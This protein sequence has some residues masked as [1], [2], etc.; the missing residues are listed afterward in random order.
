[1]ASSREMSCV[2][3]TDAGTHFSN[4]CV[5]RS[6]FKSAVIVISYNE[7]T[8]LKSFSG[9]NALLKVSL[10]DSRDIP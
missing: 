6:P 10:P 5:E 7:R 2:R 9:E 4:R 8:S 1:M 3:L